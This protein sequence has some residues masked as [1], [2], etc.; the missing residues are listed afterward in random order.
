MVSRLD[1]FCG[2]N[3]GK[4]VGCWSPLCDLAEGKR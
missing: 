3:P 1:E 4:F 2:T